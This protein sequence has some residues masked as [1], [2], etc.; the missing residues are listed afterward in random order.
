MSGVDLNTI[1]ELLGHKDLTMTLRYSHLS[2][3]HK[4]H[5]VEALGKLIVTNPS[6]SGIVEAQDKLYYSEVIESNSVT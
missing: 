2:P 6:H 1:R 5:A 3:S 4:Q